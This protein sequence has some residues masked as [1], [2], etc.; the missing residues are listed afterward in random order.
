M[1]RGLRYCY[2]LR[3]DDWC[4]RLFGTKSR[5]KLLK[6]LNAL[7]DRIASPSDIVTST[8]L[9]RYEVLAAFHVLEALG[10]VKL[11]Y[12]RGNYKLYQ[13]TNE[14]I[15]VL[16]ALENGKKFKLKV[17]IEKSTGA[18]DIESEGVEE[19]IVLSSSEES[20]AVGE[21]SS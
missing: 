4:S 13:L 11:V 2:E 20:V 17:V 7:R 21:V 19:S 1:A 12:S 10:L 5:D 14:G 9:P 3:F 16:K 15:E 6:L 8:D 18:Q